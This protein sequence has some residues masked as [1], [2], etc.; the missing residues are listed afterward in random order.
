MEKSDIRWVQRF[1]NYKK[2]LL[3]LKK[4]IDKGELNELEEQGLIQSF[5]YTYEL[6][7]NTLKDFL[8]VKGNT[9]VFGPIDAIRAAF[10]EDI[11]F[12]GEGWMKMHRDRNRS[13]HSYNE[14]IAQE[15]IEAILNQYYDLFLDLQ[16][17]FEL[18]LAK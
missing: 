4:F 2:A 7:W 15:V 18:I 14:T 5:E 12:D 16:D 8:Q 13:S 1:S 10:K 17:K 6:A 3:Q 9:G 11:I